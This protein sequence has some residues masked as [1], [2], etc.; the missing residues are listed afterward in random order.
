MC[1]THGIVSIKKIYFH[2][3]TVPSTYGVPR[4][5][6]KRNAQFPM[7]PLRELVKPRNLAANMENISSSI[8][9]DTWTNLC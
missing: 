1:S 3:V 9:N 5:A 6:A 8:S 2:W 4:V 7:R